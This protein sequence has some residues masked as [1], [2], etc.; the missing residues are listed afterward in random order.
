[1]KIAVSA[2]LHLT[3]REKNPERFHALENIL[4]QM[5]DENIG[6][7]ILAGDTFDDS[8]RNYAEFEDVCRQHPD[9]QFTVLPG[10]HDIGLSPSAVSATNLDVVNE[11]QLIKFDEFQKTLLLLPYVKNKTMGE[12]IAAQKEKLT[13]NKWILISHGDWTDGLHEPNPFEPGVY[14]PLTRIDIHNYQPLLALL[15]HIHKPLDS[16]LVHYIG[17]PCGL[18]IRE[19]GQRRFLVLDVDSGRFEERWINTDFIFFKEE[20]LILPVE[21]IAGFLE[22]EIEQRIAG[23]G[24]NDSDF[25]KVRVQVT[26]KGYCAD[27]ALARKAVMEGFEKFTF[28]KDIEP[29]LSE[30]FL[31]DDLNLREIALRANQ[32]IAELEL[33]SQAGMPSKEAIVLQAL[34]TIYGS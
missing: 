26:V 16:E 1:M 19:T 23:W 10:N 5:M 34:H 2:D 24:V 15:G 7:I 18:D 12:L 13:A 27:V 8:S 32:K 25:D 21:D 17:S 28:Y 30:V 14:M 6:R 22:N 20:L 9:L 3:S 29:D 33:R 11:I 31:A 4:R